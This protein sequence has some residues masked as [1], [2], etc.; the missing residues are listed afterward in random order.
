[1][2][3]YK[4][5]FTHFKIRLAVFWAYINK[6]QVLSSIVAGTV[7][8]MIGFF[9]TP[10]FSASD[11]PNNVDSTIYYDAGETPK[12]KAVNTTEEY[13]K[14]RKLAVGVKI[15]HFEDL[16]G[17]ESFV[18]QLSGEVTEYVFVNPLYYVEVATDIENTVLFYSVT[19]RKENFNPKFEFFSKE[20]DS[21]ETVLVTLGKTTFAELDKIFYGPAYATY[22]TGANR[23]YYF[24][25]Y[26]P[27]RPYQTHIFSINQ[28][29]VH[30]KWPILESYDESL[31]QIIDNRKMDSDTTFNI[32][33]MEYR[34]TA[35]IN[36]YTVTAPF[37]G[38][39]DILTDLNKEFFGPN[40]LQV[41]LVD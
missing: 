24:E 19:T 31:H 39:D 41:M 3:S 14:L 12:D 33:W 18:N 27:G 30:G 26:Y 34:Q 8:L 17:K 37:Y 15:T 10:Y 9:I 29:G 16:L 6:H 35:V 5:S 21:N 25:A 11:K 40:F 4:Q 36:T 7:V 32:E 38:I 23:F 2:F 13:S 22:S 1:M 28:S 20:I